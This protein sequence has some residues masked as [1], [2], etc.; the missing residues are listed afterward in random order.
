MNPVDGQARAVER[1]APTATEPRTVLSFRLERFSEAGDY[2]VVADVEMR[3]ISITG[4]LRDGDHVTVLDAAYE[5]GTLVAKKVKNETTGA[6]V[7]ARGW[8]SLRKWVAGIFVGA[9]VIVAVITIYLI[10][11]AASQVDRGP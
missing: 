5:D 10:V 6:V 1:L 3:G 11:T 4:S 9:I 2:E 8:S 7:E